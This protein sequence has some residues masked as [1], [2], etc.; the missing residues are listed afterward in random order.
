MG[1]RIRSD[2]DALLR[3]SAAA[4]AAT[5]PLAA[6]H[7]GRVAP[8]GVLANLIAIPLTA[9]VLLPV[10]LLAALAVLLFPGSRPTDLL[11]GGCATLAD[12]ALRAAGWVASQLP[13]PQPIPPPSVGAL[14][15]ALA[16][17]VSVVRV[18]ATW[19]KVV[20][21]SAGAALLAHFPAPAIAPPPPRLIALDVGQGSALIVQGRGAAILFDGATAFPG[22]ADLGR[23]A[24]VPALAAL[25][26]TRLDLVIASHADLDHRG[27]LRAVLESVPTA[28]LWLPAGGR[29][30]PAFAGLLA[31]AERRAVEVTERGQGDAGERFADLRVTPLWPPR[32]RQLS[33]NEASLVVRIEVDGSRV[34]LTG[35]IEA[36]TEAALLAA[37]ADL[38]ADVLELPHHGS[39]TSA[40]A[41]FLRA[42]GPSV[43]V[44]SA[45]CPGRFGMPH[46]VVLD[47]ADAL[48]IPVWW[49][50]RD[51]A[52]LVALSPLPAVS[53]WAP[54]L[55][56]RPG[57]H[58][59]AG[60]AR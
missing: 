49:T 32:S 13:E 27:G 26:V 5:A 39:R 38:R 1:P 22:G 14:L 16:L 2:V 8:V 29:D 11:A 43:A 6:A 58:R 53:G 19:A 54:T 59:R 36:A 18:R 42:V 51:G 56:A 41:A 10:S 12:A 4:I 24:V 50:G 45:P 47:R 20:L 33:R 31:A 34:L 9:S 44:A 23:S 48:G 7:F 57:C 25:G 37:G 52:V 15:L 17:A 21:A 30:D 28:R 40:S 3:T 35:D 46:R 55:R 60:G